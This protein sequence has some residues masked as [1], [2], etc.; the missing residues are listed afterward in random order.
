MNVAENTKP[1]FTVLEERAKSW[2][3]EGPGDVKFFIKKAWRRADGSFTPAAYQSFYERQAQRNESQELV[4][5]PVAWENERSIGIDFSAEFTL[6]DTIARTSRLSVV[7]IRRFVSKK[8][9]SGSSIPRWLLEKI[10]GEAGDQI[11]DKVHNPTLANGY[12]I[13]GFYAEGN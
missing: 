1:V 3:L 6:D 2:K 8:M 12:S 5:V 10:W 7:R 9:V 4:E 13:T 11:A